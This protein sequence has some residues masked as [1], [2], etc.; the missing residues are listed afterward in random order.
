MAGDQDSTTVPDTSPPLSDDASDDTP[1]NST[2]E[3]D[4]PVESPQKNPDPEKVCLLSC[5]FDGKTLGATRSAGQVFCIL[6][7]HAFHKQCINNFTDAPFWT[8]PFCRNLAAEVKSLHTKLDSVISQNKG[9]MD[10]INQQQNLLNSLIPVCTQITA[11]SKL[12][13]D[14]D[15]DEDDAD[16]PDMEPEGVLVIGDSLLR[17]VEPMSDDVTIDSTSGARFADVR[18]KLKAMNPKKRR[19]S[20][21][22]IVAG[23][24]DST[25]R[26]PADKIVAD[27][28]TTIETAKRIATTVVLSSIPPRNDDRGDSAKID[29]I[30]QLLLTVANE[31]DVEYV[32]HDRNFR[33]I[34]HSVDTA[35][36]LPDQLHLSTN[37]VK[38][39]L[40]NLSLADKARARPGNRVRPQKPT[41]AWNTL[42]PPSVPA[43]PPP[44]M[45]LN[46]DPPSQQMSDLD[47]NT[48]PLY[49]RGGGSP[50]SNFYP[51]PIAIWN[52]NFASSEHAYQYRKCVALGKKEAAANVLRCTKPVQAKKIG[53]DLSTDDKWE[54]MKQGAMYE[55][56]KVKARQC[57]NFFGALRKSGNCPLIE[58]TPNIYWGRGHNGEGLNMLGRL[59]MMLRSELPLMTSPTRNFTPRPTVSPPRTA[60]GRTQPHSRQQQPR[61]FN[62]GEASHTKATCRHQSPLR[63]YSCNGLGHKKKFC[64]HPR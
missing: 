13:P 48:A 53:D 42:T 11:L 12:I 17:D 41:Q 7:Q 58:N 8:C 39:L 35:L 49:F 46:V 43:P 56:L 62:C 29:N 60:F 16:E 9:L 30:N 63:C 5:K 26:K 45:S 57:P 3:P 14:A 38:K 19:Y 64:D 28:K 47:L 22:V 1:S 34:D 36:L 55:I 20:R 25:T 40:T 2:G 37:G 54:D 51:A 52:M 6:C 21:A 15:L 33:F 32:N 61:C 31:V 4:E 27:C 50:L 24:N 44:L 23:T 59:L 10:T 18:K